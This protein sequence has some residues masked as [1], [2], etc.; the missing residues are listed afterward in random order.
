MFSV[1]QALARFTN[2]RR[3]E[4]QIEVNQA[5]RRS[6][7]AWKIGD[8]GFFM[9]GQRDGGNGGS[10]SGSCKHAIQSSKLD[11]L[12]LQVVTCHILLRFQPNL[13]LPVRKRPKEAR[14][15]YDKFSS[16]LW[17]PSTFSGVDNAPDAPKKAAQ[18]RVGRLPP[19]IE[20]L[21]WF[22]RSSSRG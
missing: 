2:R 18:L 3:P 19:L 11:L 14:E 12:H 22:H 13:T 9:F 17:S 16:T 5:S 15:S 7:Q 8:I 6:Y 4:T 10:S 20:S 1:A 21:V